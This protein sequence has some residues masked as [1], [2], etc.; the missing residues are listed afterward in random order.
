MQ[1][2]AI[3]RGRLDKC[4][5]IQAPFVPFG[6]DTWLLYVRGKYTHHAKDKGFTPQN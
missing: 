6:V 5:N 3:V 2:K 1:V 4:C